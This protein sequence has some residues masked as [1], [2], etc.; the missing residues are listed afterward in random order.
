MTTSNGSIEKLMQFKKKFDLVLDAFLKEKLTEAKDISPEVLPLSDQIYRIVKNGGKRLRPAFMY[1]AYK[2]AG[3]KDEDAIL[4]T[5]MAIELLHTFALIHDDII[6][7]S[8]S[9]RGLTTPH[10]FFE[11]MHRNGKWDG[12][13]EH[14][15]V[16]AA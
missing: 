9:R 1:Y 2:G 14:F 7:Q 11:K 3:G 6:D 12:K 10:I 13:S 15:G 16:S 8:V 4:H 5:C